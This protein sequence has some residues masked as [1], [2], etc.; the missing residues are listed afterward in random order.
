MLMKTF[1]KIIDRHIISDDSFHSDSMFVKRGF[2]AR[3]QKYIDW[4]SLSQNV[5]FIEGKRKLLSISLN[6]FGALILIFSLQA[7]IFIVKFTL[8]QQ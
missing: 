8:Q 5:R 3:K 4:K 2:L 7:L 1:E 6:L